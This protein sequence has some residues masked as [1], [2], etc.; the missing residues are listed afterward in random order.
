MFR[1]GVDVEFI[2]KTTMGTP[3]PT[4]PRQGGRSYFSS[5]SSISTSNL[6]MA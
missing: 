2:V 1:F 5:F 4:F 6:N 3:I